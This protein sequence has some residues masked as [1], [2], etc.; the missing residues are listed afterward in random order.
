[1]RHPGDRH[2]ESIAATWKGLDE[3]RGVGRV[4]QHLANLADTEI[5]ALLEVHERIAAPDVVADFGAGDD[6]TAAADEELEDSERLR[7]QPEQVAALTQLAGRRI[8]LERGKTQDRGT[9]HRKLIR[10][11][12]RIHGRATRRRAL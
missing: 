5:Q 11:S 8:E 2:H 3:P 10:F 7:R 9:T 4:A 12:S 1:M 6:F